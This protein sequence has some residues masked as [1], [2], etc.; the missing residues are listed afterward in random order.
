MQMIIVLLAPSW[1]ALQQ[2][3]KASAIM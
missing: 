3:I 1:F 2:L